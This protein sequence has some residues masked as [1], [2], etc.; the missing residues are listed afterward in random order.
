MHDRS[1]GP[2]GPSSTFWHQ[3]AV[4]L[5]GKGGP[6]QPD[7]A[8]GVARDGDSVRTVDLD[9][10]P[11]LVPGGNLRVFA[12]YAG[13]SAGQLEDEL[14]QRAW[15]ICDSAPG[16]AFRADAAALWYE[17]LRRQHGEISHLAMLPDDLSV[18]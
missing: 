17:V 4:D 18:N 2:Q 15:L 5:T 10:D 3:R 9:G 16:D 12:G 14:A 7:L 13:W 6:V 11:M 8:I 1:E